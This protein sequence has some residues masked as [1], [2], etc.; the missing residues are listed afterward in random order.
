MEVKYF[1]GYKYVN[2]M[3]MIVII[4]NLKERRRNALR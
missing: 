2:L 4:V 3:K 1:F